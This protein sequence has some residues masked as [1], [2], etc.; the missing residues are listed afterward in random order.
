MVTLV[1]KQIS[2]VFTELVSVSEPVDTN[3]QLSLERQL[4]AMIN[5]YRATEA[6]S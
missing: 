6:G 1:N 3:P 4:E 5:I 2:M